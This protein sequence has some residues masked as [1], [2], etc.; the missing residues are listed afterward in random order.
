MPFLLHLFFRNPTGGLNGAASRF[1]AALSLS[2]VLAACSRE[3]RQP[4]APAAPS[5]VAAPASGPNTFKFA[6]QTLTVPAGFAVELVAGPP[7]VNRPISI[8]FDERGRLYATDS[9]G[10]SDRAPIQLEKKPHRIVRLADLDGDGRFEQSRVF[11]ENMM[12][13]Q[14]AQF[15]EGS[16]YVAAPPQI[17]KLTDQNDDGAAETRAV[18]Y[19]GKT[20]TGC[21][22]DL[23]G[24]YVGPDGWIYW[25]KGAFA[26]QQHTLPNGKA[27]VSRAAHIFRSKPDGTGLE[28]VLTGGM[29][30]P[31]GVAFTST[32]ERILS[33]TF[34]QIGVA[35]KRDG[36]IH[37]VY[38]GVYG[39]DQ[40]AIEGHIRTGDLMPIMTHMGAAAPCGSVTYRSQR[41]G[42]DYAGNVFVCYFNLRKIV[43]HELV[44]D[45]AT[46][47]TKDTDFVT[48]DSQDFRP[49]DVLEDADGSLLIVDTGGWYKICCPTS[50]LAKPDILGGIYRIRRIDAPKIEDPRGLNIAWAQLTAAQLAE[51][52]GD[53]RPDVQQ[54]AIHLLG[55]KGPAA[56][57]ALSAVLTGAR[58]AT[59]QKNAL[60][61]LTRIDAPAARTAVRLA[62]DHTDLSAVQIALQGVSLWRDRP[63]VERLRGF[64]RGNRPALTRL[65]AEALGRI[66]DPSAVG[67]LLAA[68]GRLPGDTFTASGTPAG[69]AEQV[70]EH[71][72]IYALI[73]IG[74]P[75]AVRATLNA[76][77]HPRM[78]RA[79]LVALDQ[80]EG[81][82]LTAADVIGRLD[83]PVPVL[84]KTAG[85]IVGHNAAWGDALADFFRTRL[86]GNLDREQ[87]RADVQLQL[88]Q[89]AK[90]VPIQTL[91]VAS[92][93]EAGVSLE[94][95]LVAL[96][97]MAAVGL[98][99]T[100]PAFLDALAVVLADPNGNPAI[101]RQAITTTRALPM[102]K[103]GHAEL[104]A[105]LSRLGRATKLPAELRVQA[106]AIA[107]PTVLE[108]A[109]FDFLCGELEVTKP[110]LVRGAAAD[111]LAKAPLTP[112]QQGALVDTIKNVGALEAPKL[113]PAFEKAPQEALGLK[114]VAALGQANGRSG[115]RAGVLKPLF[116][117]YPP[118]V[119]QA[120]EALLASIDAEAAGQNAQTD[121]LLAASANG[122]IRR[123]QALFNSDKTACSLCHAIGYLGGRLGPDLTSIGKIRDDRELLEAIIFPSATFVR[124]YEPFVVTTKSGETHSGIMRKD[125]AEEVVLA[126]GPQTEQRIA[127][128]DIVEV[129][130]GVVSPMPPGLHA[131]LAPQEL[132]DLLA[133]LNSRGK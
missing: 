90:S 114:L 91:L 78:V 75:A 85:W 96:R 19:D 56:V 97:A 70:L 64:V 52:L 1:L 34:F 48:S 62:L 45:G 35:G 84:K 103:T 108:P 92:L 23:H 111:V 98:P 89:L 15:Y 100:P 42:A 71:A 69:Q 11:A 29:D 110:L 30:N 10:L 63:A 106:L 79:A 43:R 117:K 77:S 37:S 127:R 9:S 94:A 16:L 83:S 12:F 68:A 122:D 123:G 40:S 55:K 20:L 18:W 86:R 5:S 17:W 113:L 107:K 26:E 33:G 41:F 67:D 101:L 8:A 3:T 99:T 130:P 38:G 51:L 104:S 22:N 116:A 132:A 88:A 95:R 131:V 27:F 129:S 28:P 105:V 25:T 61:A 120:G 102:P 24:P 54:Q 82:D 59:A 118:S 46:Y 21:A 6:T 87:E 128:A 36:L 31:V 109:L 49:T 13:P 58:T 126:T 39:K 50:Q 133:F 124:G 47:T 121:R 60:W 115:L 112:T 74:S 76:S 119:Q 81:G 72:L 53:A 65:A 66:G 57:T 73:E 2:V 4:K 14:G 7:L 125:T 93:T 44:P 80:M 32:G